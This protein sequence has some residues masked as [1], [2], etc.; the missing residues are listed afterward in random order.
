MARSLGLI[1]EI[2]TPD[3]VDFTFLSLTAK[4]SE[5][6]DPLIPL[7]R[8]PFVVYSLKES[9]INSLADLQGK[10]FTALIGGS[11]CPCTEPEV[12]YSRVRLQR[13]SQALKMLKIGRVDAVSGPAIRLKLLIAEF[14]M[15]EM[16]A[17]PL[18]FEWRDIWFQSSKHLAQSNNLHLVRDIMRS[19]DFVA[20]YQQ[21]LTVVF[22]PEQQKYVEYIDLATK[23]P[24]PIAPQ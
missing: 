8:T 5:Y 3:R 4:R 10:L 9:P 21:L 11:G 17:P 18:I 16:L 1:R 15:A 6:V 7:Y 12:E 14:E 23:V 22:T 13:H 2:K 24:K 20:Y 19:P